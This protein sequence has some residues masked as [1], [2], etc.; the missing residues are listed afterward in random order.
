MHEE[1]GV[2]DELQIRS[3][4]PK[5]RSTKHNYS[6]N[7][8]ITECKSLELYNGQWCPCG[9]GESEY[10]QNQRHDLRAGDLSH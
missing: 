1:N 7:L 3:S 4:L 10:S 6:D 9:S 5:R 8:N 2:L